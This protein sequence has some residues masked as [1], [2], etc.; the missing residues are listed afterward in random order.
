MHRPTYRALR[1]GTETDA[2]WVTQTNDIPDVCV[3]RGCC[4]VTV[5]RPWLR[6]PHQQAI[7]GSSRSHV[8]RG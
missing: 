4:S 6:C 3:V 2:M 1:D 8:G 5:R 7:A